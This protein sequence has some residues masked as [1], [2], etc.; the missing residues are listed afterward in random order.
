MYPSPLRLI[1]S[2]PNPDSPDQP[3]SD[4]LADVPDAAILV[5]KVGPAEGRQ[6]RTGQAVRFVKGPLALD[7]I[8][9]AARSG[10]AKAPLMLLALRFKADASR[11]P[12]VKPPSRVLMEWGFSADD[13]SRAIRALERAGLVEVQRRRGRPPLIQLLPWRVGSIG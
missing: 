3:H 5:R 10:H 13:R 12:W 1:A 11:E 6:H 7:W 4:P 8:G 9:A 2:Q